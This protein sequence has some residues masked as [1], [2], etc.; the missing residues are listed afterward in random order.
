HLPQ[1][2]GYLHEEGMIFSPDGHCRAFDARAA[3][4]VGGNGMGMVLLKPLD[5][6]LADGD[7]IHA[8]IKGSAINND[9][10]AKVGYTAPSIDGQSEVIAEAHAVA[11]IDPESVTYIEAHGTG[12]ELGDP[13]EI[14]ALTGAFRS[15]A[16]GF[17][18]IG[19][20]KSNVGHLDSAAGVVGLIKTVLAL[21]RRTIP[22][23][24]HFERPNPKIDFSKTPFYVA[25]ARRERVRH[26]RHQ[27]ARGPRR[28]AGGRGFAGFVRAA[29][30]R[31]FGEIAGR[32]RSSGEEP[33]RAPGT[34][35]PCE[36][37]RR[38][39]HIAPRPPRV[40]ASPCG[41]RPRR[42]RG[43]PAAAIIR[44]SRRRAWHRGR[45]GPP[46]R[47]ASDVSVRARTLLGRIEADAPARL[48]RRAGFAAQCR[49]GG[50][51]LRAGV[52]AVGSLD[53]R[54]ESNGPAMA[55]LRRRFRNRRGDRQAGSGDGGDG[56]DHRR[57]KSAVDRR[58]PSPDDRSPAGIA[59]ARRCRACA[60]ARIQQ[61]ASP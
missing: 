47:S 13:I 35:S 3:G 48:R 55:D 52:E 29:D 38:G 7:C 11:G 12:T 39:V 53:S 20:V 56:N 4:T 36:S 15:K 49:S 43:D 19:S 9:G 37:R 5:D 60:R 2:E 59:R 31:P 14:A 34:A 23:T 41:R 51:V 17:C 25:A 8:V 24:L 1:T 16:A 42:R 18:A 27:R 26:R 57:R 61:P 32:A 28:S 58:G 44:R 46:P 50:V 40:S 10:T 6:A 22:P 54:R 33:R 30:A 21:E 45:S